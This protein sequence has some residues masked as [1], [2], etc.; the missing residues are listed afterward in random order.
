MK[1]ITYLSL[2][3]ATLMTAC[4]PAS[5]HESETPV[6]IEEEASTTELIAVTVHT[7]DTVAYTAQQS[8][9]I[10]ADYN[11][12]DK[13][14]SPAVAS[15]SMVGEGLGAVRTLTLD[16]GNQVVEELITLDE[17]H[18]TI[19]YKMTQGNPI[20]VGYVGTMKVVTVD[21]DSHSVIDWTSAFESPV[22]QDSAGYALIKGVHLLMFDNLD[23]EAASE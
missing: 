1:V 10:V 3:F 11:A 22:G 2:V 16:D 6:A 21:D 9:E 20:L 14:L 19:Q 8:W 5:S 23:K 13:W 18:M 12:L 4:G 15:S 17:E 7:V